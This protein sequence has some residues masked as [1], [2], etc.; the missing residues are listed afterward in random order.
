MASLVVGGVI[1]PVALGG[2]R[3]EWL[4]GVDRARAFD[5][6]F[7]AS[8][9]GNPKRD[10]HFSTPPIRSGRA[11]IYEAILT[12][13]GAQ[14]CSGDLLGGAE[15]VS[16]QSETVTTWTAIGT[17]VE[18]AAAHTAS[19]V[20]MDLI[21]DDD[22]AVA[23]G[24][25]RSVTLTGD[26]LKAFSSHVKAGTSTSFALRFRDATAAVNRFLASFDWTGGVPTLVSASAGTFLGYEPLVDGVFRL[27]MQTTSA[28]AA[29]SN[30]IRL[31]PA[32]TVALAVAN[33]GDTYFGGVQV[34]N[35]A[36]SGPYVKTTTVAISNLTASCFAELTGRTSV[37]T[38]NGLAEVFDFSLYEQ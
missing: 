25:L 7:R 24:E 14:V 36:T 20:S 23:E 6:T 26:G 3:R 34:E 5:Q 11:G 12:A 10:W 38:G 32:T 8:V 22:A 35:R 2:S 19:G 29:N 13:V 1:I 16:I 37:K 28:I 33:T 9:T 21:G 30:E 15:N 4:D 31:Y 27:L 17:P 18:T